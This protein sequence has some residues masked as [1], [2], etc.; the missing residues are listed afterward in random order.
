[1]LLLNIELHE[2]ES[3]DPNIPVVSIILFA[4][5][6]QSRDV[7]ILENKKKHAETGSSAFDHAEP[8]LAATPLRQ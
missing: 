8:Y 7:S 5:F 3:P 1:M 4:S 6:T 2:N